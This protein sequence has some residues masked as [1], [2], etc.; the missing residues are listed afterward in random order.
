MFTKKLTNSYSYLEILVSHLNNLSGE[1]IIESN[2]AKEP[3]ET[4]KL[5]NKEIML[6]NTDNLFF[7]YKWNFYTI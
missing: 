3:Q 5:W 6:K 1:A 7:L 4:I 2:K